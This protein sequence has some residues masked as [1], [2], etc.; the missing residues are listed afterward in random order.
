MKK[1]WLKVI[2][3]L[4]VSSI[5]G[6]TLSSCTA[7]QKFVEQR[8]VSKI[9]LQPELNTLEQTKRQLDNLIDSQST[10]LQLYEDYKNIRSKLNAAYQAAKIIS[11]NEISNQ[12]QLQV[13]IV[14]LRDAI[15]KASNDKTFFDKEHSDLVSAYNKLKRQV[16]S[17]SLLVRSLNETRYSAIRTNALPIYNQARVIITNTLQAID[18]N[19]YAMINN[20]NRMSNQ[21]SNLVNQMQNAD[22]F[23]TFKRFDLNKENFLGNFLN[24]DSVPTEYSFVAYSSDIYNYS[25]NFATPKIWVNPYDNTNTN[26]SVIVHNSEQLTNTSWIYSLRPNKNSD[27][28]YEFSFEYY[29]PSQVAYLYFPYKSINR[30]SNKIIID[31]RLNHRENTGNE[32]RDH[33]IVPTPSVD[34]I[35]VIRLPI[36][37]LRYGMNTVAIRSFRN[38][39]FPIIG[40]MYISSA[41]DRDSNTLD[42]IYNDI[43]GNVVSL[44][45]PGQITVDVLK[46]YGLASSSAMVLREY[47]A[48]VNNQPLTLD[49]V[50]QN[51]PY[52][53]IGNLGGSDPG[54]PTSSPNAL[55]TFSPSTRTYTFYVNAPRAGAYH[56]SGVYNSPRNRGLLF[57][58][59]ATTGDTQTESIVKVMNLSTGST[60]PDSTLKTFDTSKAETTVQNGVRTL[61]LIKGLNKI[62]VTGLDDQGAPNLGNITFTL[63]S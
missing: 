41:S 19:D 22:Q 46:A 20:I 60:N 8:T 62:T 54:G 27:T 29:G 10:T 34:S 38:E 36:T 3:F 18:P 28:R 4:G 45:N 24:N 59:T 52:Y 25:Y 48:N 44:N 7:L 56:I 9:T 43:F 6:L 49:G 63:A 37:N 11:D 40:N 32:F 30:N 1:N 13:A 26:S 47:S 58:T 14:T 50:E 21:I 33:I 12:E 2:S 39:P 23:A 61:T 42:K 17:A 57:S 53:L 15:N 55:R 35:N 16:Q 51:H 5:L 31:W